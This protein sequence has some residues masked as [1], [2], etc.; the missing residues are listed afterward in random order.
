MADDGWYQRVAAEVRA[1]F[2][3]GPRLVDELECV[4]SVLLAIV[5]G[6]LADVQNISWA[7][8]SGYMVMRGHVSESLWRGA[9][10]IIGTLG[11]ALLAFLIV[12]QV[13]HSPAATAAVLA[14]IGGTT[15]YG[16]LMGR[17]SYARLFVGLTFAMILMDKLEHP[18]HVV[19]AFISTRIR[20]TAAGTLACI[21][22]SMISTLTLRQRWPSLPSPPPPR[23]SWLPDA[24]RHASQGAIALAILPFLWAAFQIPQLSQGAITIMALML[25]PLSGIGKSGFRPVSRRIALRVIGCASG[26]A[27]AAAFLLLAH[28]STYLA[29]PV[30][31]AGMALGVM[32]GRHIEN[33]KSAFAYGGTQF[34]LVILVTLVPDS[35]LNAELSPGIARL[36]GSL[37]GILLLLPVLAGWHL[38]VGVM[39]KRSP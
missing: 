1:V 37:V 7:A 36:T 29:T 25:I 14:L 27:F 31:I 5:F 8:F 19:E 12:P 39:E 26:A 16:A 18:Q 28:V 38:V 13:W 3:T 22:I 32:L 10:R 23:F 2:T 30:L 4:A 34:V 33:G 24:A 15:I 6:H 21:L 17:H 35:Y 11:G 20:E 9:L